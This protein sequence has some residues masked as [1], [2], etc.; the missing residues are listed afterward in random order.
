MENK[1]PIKKIVTLV[2]VALCVPIILFNLPFGTVGV[3]ER[4]IQTRTN[5]ITGK[6]F[7]E[8]LY[9]RVPLIEKVVPK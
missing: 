9:F 5:A 6:V 7:G 4:G 8:G 3:G 1:P 2:I